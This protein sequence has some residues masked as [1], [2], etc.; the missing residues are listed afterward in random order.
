MSLNYFEYTVD[1]IIYIYIYI[2]NVKL[3]IE[4]YTNCDS[5]IHMNCV[6]NVD[7]PLG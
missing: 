1:S 5:R 7:T 6:T 3:P 4:H 2:S